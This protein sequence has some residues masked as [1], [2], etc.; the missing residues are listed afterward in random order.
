VLD[1]G[2]KKV[3]GGHTEGTSMFLPD[4]CV[5]SPGDLLGLLTFTVYQ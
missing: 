4:L 1:H 2:H 3:F 5:F